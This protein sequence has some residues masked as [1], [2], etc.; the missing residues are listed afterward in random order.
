VSSRVATPLASDPPGDGRRPE[1]EGASR[2][3]A[4]APRTVNLYA[5]QIIVSRE[6]TILTT[7]LGSCVAVCLWDAANGSGGMNHFLLPERVRDGAAT[8]YASAACEQLIARMVEIGSEPRRL[9]AKVFGGAAVIDALRQGVQHLGERNV[10][11]AMALLEREK[12]PVVAE[13]VL[14]RYGRKLVFHTHSGVA[15]VKAIQRGP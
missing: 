6:P 8:R 13:D 4:P 9:V 10:A 3:L 14:G 2:S 11:T 1:P 5:G 7:I 12:I 15:W